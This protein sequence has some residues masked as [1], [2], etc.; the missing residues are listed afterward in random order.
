MTKIRLSKMEIRNFKK[1][2]ALDLAFKGESASITGAN[3]SG[4]TSIYKAYYWC[5]TGK[6]LEPNETIQTLDENN[7]IVHKVDTSVL[8][9]FIID[10]SYEVRLERKLIEEWRAAGMPN[11]QLKGTVQQRF[12]NDIPLSVAE[13]NA[14]LNSIY[15]L[16]KLLL[17]SK[18][19]LGDPSS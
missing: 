1:I 3:A 14:K 19:F 4:K 7:E 10:D 18:I 15:E 9:V 13:F 12:F 6:T 17:L 8:V 2:H 5:L 16:D 11:E